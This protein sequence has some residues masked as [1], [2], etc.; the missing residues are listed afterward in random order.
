[1]LKIIALIVLVA[2][3]VVLIIAA[4]RPDR[5]AISR[6]ATMKA[7]PEKI[8]PYLNDLK[9]N[10]DWS[11][12]E[13]TDPNMRRTYGEPAAGVGATYEFAGNNQAGAGRIAIVE[14]VPSSKVVL[15]LDM[16][17]PM[18]A[19]N[20]VTYTLVPKGGET[21]V[22]WTMEGKQPFPIRV[23]CVFMNMD[24]MMGNTFSRGLATLKSIVEK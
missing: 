19:S 14:S 16:V 13:K 18:K 9:R 5:F 7:P 17:K 3:I 6:S 24:K 23:I 22:T 15:S 2:V 10:V 12:F 8:F 4:R 1:M 20:I 21:E 11:P